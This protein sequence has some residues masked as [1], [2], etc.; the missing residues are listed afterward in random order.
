MFDRFVCK[1]YNKYKNKKII[2][3]QKTLKEKWNYID[4]LSSLERII[5][6]KYKYK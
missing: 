6:Y 4:K 5:K 3:S 1:N 2:I